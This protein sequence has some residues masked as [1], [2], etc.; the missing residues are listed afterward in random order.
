MKVKNDTSADKRESTTFFHIDIA[1]FW[2]K[3]P[4][5]TVHRQIAYL[6]LDF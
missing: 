4:M 5:D 2:K 3:T 6:Y 1:Q